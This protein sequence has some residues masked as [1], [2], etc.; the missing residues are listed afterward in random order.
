LWFTVGLLLPVSRDSEEGFGTS[1][2]IDAF[3]FLAARSRYDHRLNPMLD[4]NIKSLDEVGQI[5]MYEQSQQ[6]A[7]FCHGRID[8]GLSTQRQNLQVTCFPI[9]YTLV[10]QDLTLSREKPTAQLGQYSIQ[11]VSIADDGTTQIHVT[12]TD[13][14]LSA[15]P[16]ECFASF[17]FGQKGL[18]LVSA[19]KNRGTAKMTSIGCIS[20]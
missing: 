2:A 15:R 10:A 9:T 14:F 5:H 1:I 18:E 7:Y 17:E 8:N 3:Y 13:T 6:F 12:P 20:H 19:S 4:Y 16:G 11:L